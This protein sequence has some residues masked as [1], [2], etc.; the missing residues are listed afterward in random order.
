MEIYVAIAHDTGTHSCMNRQLL[1]YLDVHYCSVKQ[2]TATA[3]EKFI[4]ARKRQ[5]VREKTGD[6]RGQKIPF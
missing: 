5:V 3:I 2:T 1:Y 4:S 6:T